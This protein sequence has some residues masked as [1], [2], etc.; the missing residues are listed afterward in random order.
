M[1]FF[2]KIRSIELSNLLLLS[3]TPGKC[4]L[5]MPENVNT[6]LIQYSQRNEKKKKRLLDCTDKKCCIEIRNIGANNL[7]KCKNQPAVGIKKK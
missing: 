5:S 2:K 3:R 1:D 4:N 6:L 7:E